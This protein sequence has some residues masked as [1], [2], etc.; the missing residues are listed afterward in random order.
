MMA[1]LEYITPEEARA[2]L[3]VAYKRSGDGAFLETLQR[4]LLNPVE[5]RDAN[6][7]RKLHPLLVVGLVLLV[8][9]AAAIAF[10]SFG[11]NS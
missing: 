5:Q 10:F 1:D 4:P 7:R 6:G 8:L 2:R 11:I 3:L 9:A